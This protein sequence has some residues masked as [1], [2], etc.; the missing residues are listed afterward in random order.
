MEARPPLTLALDL[1]TKMGWG[2]GRAGA[3]PDYGTMLLPAGG[4][5]GGLGRV[6]AAAEQ[7]LDDLFAVQ[8]FERVIM[9]APL[10]PAAQTQAHTARVQLG[11]AAVV[12]L[13]CF[14]RDIPV[15]EA[16]ATT[17]RAKVLGMGR[18]KK[19]DVIAWCQA[20][21]WDPGDNNAA[22]ALAL[23]AYAQGVRRQPDLRRAA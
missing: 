22:D 14:G 1:S 13:W 6:Y 3:A 5:A 20:Q 4:G 17:V 21:G 7:A 15:T 11:L 23:L 8:H 19:A 9:E 12:D 16:A 2:C 18:A 10:P